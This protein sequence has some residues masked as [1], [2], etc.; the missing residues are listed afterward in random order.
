MLLQGIEGCIC[1]DCVSLAADYLSGLEHGVKS[2][3][4][5][6]DSLVKPKE[7][8]PA[9]RDCMVKEASPRKSRSSLTSM[10]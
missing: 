10:S 3:P 1:S 5:R 4:G 8:K 2:E 6:I 9:P 7:I